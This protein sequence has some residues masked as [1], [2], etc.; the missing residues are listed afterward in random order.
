MGWKNDRYEHGLASKGIKTA[1]GRLR[2]LSPSKEIEL[3]KLFDYDKAGFDT[4]TLLIIPSHRML[5]KEA[6]WDIEEYIEWLK[7]NSAFGEDARLIIYLKD[8]RFS[9]Q[10]DMEEFDIENNRL[11]RVEGI[12]KI[13]RPLNINNI[14]NVVK[15]DAFGTY[16]FYGELINDDELKDI[17]DAINVSKRQQKEFAQTYKGKKVLR[18]R[19]NKWF[20]IVSPTKLIK[21]KGIRQKPFTT[22]SQAEL[23]RLEGRR[24]KRIS[25]TLADYPPSEEAVRF[26]KSPKEWRELE[27]KK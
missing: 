8:E 17:Y 21:A 3:K 20:K 13:V 16:D 10:F 27:K 1:S 2:K 4:D 6:V 9:K 26:A 19:D 22:K 7:G 25:I 14:E 18:V 12:N 15:T 11:V 23:E 24:R 5:K